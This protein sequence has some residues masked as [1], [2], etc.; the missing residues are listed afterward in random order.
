MTLMVA[1]PLSP[2]L[3]S[4]RFGLMTAAA[5]VEGRRTAVILRGEADSSA[6]VALADVLS[7]VTAWR[8]DDVVV[9][10][11]ELTFIDA[12][13]VGVLAECR[14]LLEHDGRRMT[15]RSPSKLA[16]RLL[17]KSA[18]ADRIEAAGGEAQPA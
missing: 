1:A 17:R 15:L 16:V 11:A 4:V 5:H 6:T 12:A 8:S 7:W 9:D 18:L 2:A 13:A 10:L 3:T 14:R